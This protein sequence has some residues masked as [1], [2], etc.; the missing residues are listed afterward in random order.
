MGSVAMESSMKR[1]DPYIVH[2][3]GEPG[4]GVGRGESHAQG[5]APYYV[6]GQVGWCGRV[7]HS[8]AWCEL[9]PGQTM[10][11]LHHII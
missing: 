11:K 3:V 2:I 1:E 10:E 9:E 4:D 5:R 6:E 7:K 8:T